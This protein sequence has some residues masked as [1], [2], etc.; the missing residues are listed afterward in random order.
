MSTGAVA[1][2]FGAGQT[3][4]GQN[5]IALGYGAGIPN[6]PAHSFYTIRNMEPVNSSNATSLIYDTVTGQVGPAIGGSVYKAT[7]TPLDEHYAD[8]LINLRP[9]GFTVPPSPHV[10]LG[11]DPIEVATYYPQLVQY[12]K[13]N[14]PE[15]VDY[16]LLSVLLLQYIQEH[17]V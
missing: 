8:N 16:R 4:M 10:H 9:I 14:Q 5:A 13:Y 11:L 17:T 12:D 1:I 6:Q 15:S 3:G 7:S 2:G